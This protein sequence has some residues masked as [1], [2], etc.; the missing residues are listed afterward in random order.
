MELV[1]TLGVVA[2]V[3]VHAIEQ[4]EFVGVFCRLGHQL[5]DPEPALAVLGEIEDRPGV[6]LVP[7]LGFVVEGVELRGAAAHAEEDDPFRAGGEAR[8]LREEVRRVREGLFLTK[9]RKGEIA[10]AA[11]RLP[12]EGAA[13]EM[14]FS[15]HNGAH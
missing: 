12:K 2:G 4:A 7:G 14:R 6:L 15:R 13:G 3:G 8:R 1:K 9:R 10:E 11:G 5:G